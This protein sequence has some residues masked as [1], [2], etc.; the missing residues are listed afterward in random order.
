[1]DGAGTL[2][3][4]GKLS[5]R[6]AQQKQQAVQQGGVRVPKGRVRVPKGRVREAAG[7]GELLHDESTITAEKESAQGVSPPA[8]VIVQ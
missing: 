1:M 7:D 8:G 4:R 5:A 6:G 2:K 3:G